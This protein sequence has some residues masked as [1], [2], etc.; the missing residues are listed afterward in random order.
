MT[1]VTGLLQQPLQALQHYRP[2]LEG[3]VWGVILMVIILF[4]FGSIL[5]TSVRKD[6]DK[7]EDKIDEEN[8]DNFLKS[9]KDIGL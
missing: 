4:C 5:Q 9:K 7:D 8:I 6:Y 1:L 2:Y 3:F